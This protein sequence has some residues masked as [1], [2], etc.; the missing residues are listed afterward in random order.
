M[1]E[2]RRYTQEEWGGRD[3]RPDCTLEQGTREDERNSYGAL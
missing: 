1:H 3:G 2:Y